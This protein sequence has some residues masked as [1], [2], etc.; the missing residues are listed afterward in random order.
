MCKYSISLWNNH[1]LIKDHQD[2]VLDPF[3]ANE[4][5][6]QQ[7][8]IEWSFAYQTISVLEI[9]DVMMSVFCSELMFE[10]SIS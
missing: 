10:K 9:T 5:Q 1:E 2:C 7:D 6:N 4:A 8:K 3:D